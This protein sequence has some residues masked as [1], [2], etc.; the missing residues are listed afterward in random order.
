MKASA[1]ADS[2]VR[3]SVSTWDPLRLP[4]F[5]ALWLASLAS[6]VGSWMH[7]VAASWLMTSL[8]TS[9]A[10]VALLQTANSAPNFLL[11]LPAGALADV[12]DRRRL[13][14]ATQAWQLGV[15]GLLGVLTLGQVTTPAVLL[16][17]TFALAAGSAL[18]LPA[19]GALTPE[20]VPREQLAAAISLN[21]VVLTGAQAIG[22]AIG[23]LLV[24][25]LGSGAVFIVNAVSFLA[26]VAAVATWRRPPRSSNLPPEHVGSAIRT[27][28]RYV[29]NAPE[30][31]VVLLRAAAY[32][33]AF[34][35]LPAL[36]AI[37][38]RT[39][40]H[41][42]AADFG[43]L[44]AALGIGGVAGAVVLPRARARWSV[45]R[46]VILGTLTYAGMLAGIANLRSFAWVCGLLLVAGLAGMAN[47]SSLN[48]AAQSVLPDWVRG[49]GLALVQLTFMF[50]FALGGAVWGALAT[51][52]GLPA[53]L[54]TAAAGLAA[55]AVLAQF[56]RLDA[57]DAVDV[58][59]A[60]QAEPYVPVSLSP[61]DGPVLLS[62]EYRIPAGS[63]DAFLIAVADLAR[64]RRRDGAMHWGLYSDP[65]N[66]E[67]HVE[68]FLAPSWS[69]HL[70]TATRQTRT[71]ADAL[72]RV[73]LF[74][75]ADE[76]PKLTAMLGHKGLGHPHQRSR[77]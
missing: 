15:A 5:R 46:I 44:L 53:T 45:D 23:G 24:A 1:A 59:L 40:L 42:S 13:V 27:G 33:L 37:F 16:A 70:R 7:L 35:A 74:H 56:L 64:V 39:R 69:E 28:V 58:T 60:E 18:G 29:A 17:M 25:W 55:N 76:V 6:N 11:A 50:A 66:P 61:N 68:T 31:R 51:H 54:E 71:D 26:V 9:A 20:L 19:F 75:H 32:V 3:E 41:G 43:L 2:A 73:R 38:T 21:S 62:V 34:S 63:L 8:T 57:V 77:P 47:M 67:R 65:N 52:L 49:R 4:V 12:L 72:D 48:I 14:I 22:P 36:L 30:F 10:L